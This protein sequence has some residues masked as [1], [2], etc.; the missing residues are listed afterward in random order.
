MKNLK[1]YFLVPAIFIL[2]LG[3]NKDSDN[4][5]TTEQSNSND[6]R[7]TVTLPDGWT[8]V[9]GS[10]LE[11][12]YQKGT[13][14]FMIKN[15]YVLNQKEIDVAVNEAKKHI[16]QYFDDAT[17][18]ETQTITV[19]GIDARSFTFTNTIKAAGMVMNMKS[20]QVYVMI[21][22]KCYLIYFGT[23]ESSFNTLTDDFTEILNGIK[24]ELKV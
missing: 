10:V 21:D 7:I 9:D 13:A 8:K 15:E 16:E 11:H 1:L 12:Q 6:L 4:E 5:L 14:S 17:C 18:T 20:Q 3:C 22:A 2:A 19:D 23:P 24:F